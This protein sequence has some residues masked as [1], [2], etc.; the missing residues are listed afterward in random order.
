MPSDWKKEAEDF[1][2][3]WDDPGWQHYAEHA[4]AELK[5]M[6]EGSA[7]AMA[8]VPDQEPD[9]RYCCELGYMVMLDKPI[10][11]VVEAGVKVPDKLV[12]ICDE[13]VEAGQI[14]DPAFEQRMK[15]AIARVQ[16]KLPS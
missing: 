14:G 4:R 8:F 11:A 9:P 2:S 1:E 16:A 5:P 15:D 6:I 10:I 3:P 12:K 13:I 7:I